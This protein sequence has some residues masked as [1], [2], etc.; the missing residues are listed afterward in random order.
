MFTQTLESSAEGCPSFIENTSSSSIQVVAGSRD[1]LKTT[2][3]RLAEP[4]TVFFYFWLAP[5]TCLASATGLAKHL[6]YSFIFGRGW[7]GGVGGAR[8]GAVGGSAGWT[9]EVR[10][11]RQPGVMHGDDLG[12]GGVEGWG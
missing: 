6:V 4:S 12:W 3:Q 2:F 5:G 1:M 10:V 8:A 9:G 7:V 11:C